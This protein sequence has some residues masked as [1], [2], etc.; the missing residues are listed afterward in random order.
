MMSVPSPFR[1]FS[2]L[3]LPILDLRKVECG[4]FPPVYESGDE[5]ITPNTFAS[6]VSR[7]TTVP[8]CY[9]KAIWFFLFLSTPRPALQLCG[10]C[11]F[12][13]VVVVVVVVVAVLTL[14]P[15]LYMERV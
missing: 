1:S 3:C 13:V 7:T 12:V 15:R 11:C 4:V 9:T 6:F 14:I 2:D 10:C 8:K 5:D